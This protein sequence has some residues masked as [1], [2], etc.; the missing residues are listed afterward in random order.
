MRYEDKKEETEIEGTESVSGVVES[1][2]YVNPTNDYTVIEL[3]VDQ[4]GD[5]TT[6]VGFLPYVSEGEAVTLYGKWMHHSSYGEQF[7]VD[8]FEKRLPSGIVDMLKYLSSGTLKGIGKATARKLIDKFGEDTFDVIEHH[9]EWLSDIPGISRKKAAEISASFQEQQGLRTLLMLCRGHL[10]SVAI[11]RIYRTWGSSAVGIIQK[12]PYRMCSSIYGIGF[13]RVDKLAADLGIEPDSDSRIS[14]GIR[15]ILTYNAAG[16][17]HTCLKR[18]QLVNASAALLS[19]PEERISDTLDRECKSGHIVCYL[20]SDGKTEFYQSDTIAHAESFIA[21]KLFMMKSGCVTFTHDDVTRLIS[22]IEIDWQITY[23]DKQREALYTALDEGVMILTGGPG[24]G[25]TTVVR[26]LVRLFEELDLPIALCA[27]T[28][29][30]AKRLSEASGHATSTV[31]RLLEM[32]KS[33]TDVPSFMRNEKFPLEQMVIIVDEASML[34]VPLTSS[35]LNAI[36]RGGRIIFIGD[37]DQ[38]PSVGCGNVLGDLIDSGV[39]PTV[40]LNE[41]FRQSEESTIIQN[42]HRINQ[43]EYPDLTKKTGDFF[44]LSR[45]TDASIVPTVLSLL[46]QRLPKAYGKEIVENIQVISPGRKGISGTEQLNIALQEILNPPSSSKPSMHVRDVIFRRGDRIMQTRNNYEIE[47]KKDSVQGTG[48]FNGDIGM[49]TDVDEKEG[50]ITVSFEGRV[51][52]YEKSDLDEI[53]HAYAIT[54]HKSQGSEYPIVIFPA[55][56]CP[57]VL[58]T[59]NLLYTA[60]TRAQKMVIIVGREDI[61]HEMTENNRQVLRYTTLLDRLHTLAKDRASQ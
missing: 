33:D 36:P 29:R 45:P 5:L 2:V 47:W 52:T 59:R 21:H 1:I 40:C 23:A 18:E 50:N 25:K 9:P 34:D 11:N 61:I 44:F 51:V 37:S 14:A 27:P 30:A 17:G 20:C 55:Y 12:D 53:D 8:C 57:P 19:L 7:S 16:N 38:L 22:R 48:I 24:T 28:G 56:A 39:F 54:V 13:A 3:I 32:Q 58:R 46:T 4:T 10:G 49:I 15:Y 42:A 43:G 31:H 26:A 6:A 60:L 41:V 35:L